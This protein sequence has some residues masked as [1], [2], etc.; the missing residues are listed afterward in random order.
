LYI[1]EDYESSYEILLEKAKLPSLFV[2]RQRN[3]A[4]ETFKILNDLAPPVLK[5]LVVKKETRYNFRYSNIL[6]VPSINTTTYGKRSFRYAAPVLW[7]SLPEHVRSITNFSHFKN[8][9]LNWD[10]GDCKC[11][12]CGS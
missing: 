9:I 5:D 4:L 11:S 10:G 12:A 3:M 7:N 8:Q 2:K 6:H 1:Y